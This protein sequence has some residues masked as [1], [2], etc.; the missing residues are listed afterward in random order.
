VETLWI[1]LPCEGARQ[2]KCNKESQ[3]RKGLKEWQENPLSIY[4]QQSEYLG[5]EEE[6]L[7]DQK[8]EAV[9]F[10]LSTTQRLLLLC[11]WLEG[12]PSPGLASLSQHRHKQL[13]WV[14]S[15]GFSHLEQRL[16]HCF[17]EGVNACCSLSWKNRDL[18]SQY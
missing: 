4:T 2:D 5:T 18:F 3:S 16:C 1:A 17:G 6:H 7:Q 11:Q 8:T 9:P 10:P 15:S 13:C 12:L 14:F